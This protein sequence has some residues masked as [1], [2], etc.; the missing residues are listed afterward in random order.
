MQTL[1]LLMNQGGTLGWA[2]AVIGAFGVLLALF[3]LFGAALRSP[4]KVV[5]VLAMACLVLSL[6]TSLTGLI[7]TWVGRSGAEKAAIGK[8]A[9][10][11]ERARLKGF[12]AARA[13]VTLAVPLAAPPLLLALVG[14]FVAARRRLE[15]E[16]DEP[17]PGLGLAVVLLLLDAGAVAASV[18]VQRQP[19]PGEAL[20]DDGWHVREVSDAL[21]AN[22]WGRCLDA[23]WA[24]AEQSPAHTMGAHADNQRK[25]VEHFVA[26]GKVEDLEALAAVKWLE[27]PKLRA[28]LDEKLAAAT[29]ARAAAPTPAPEPA[30]VERNPSVR[31]AASPAADIA[32]VQAKAR[33]CFDKAAKKKKR[34]SVATALA[35]EVSAAGKVVAVRDTGSGRPDAVRKCAV[36]SAKTLKLKAG[37]ARKLDVVLSFP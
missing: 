6:A 13:G 16:H 22:E 7:C 24:L 34:L 15:E 28:A 20:D 18:M 37:D 8:R 35:I 29:S 17:P 33:A 23:K 9:A 11:A 2:V 30:L 10:A 19:P 25:C 36:A 5:R 12:L 3:V 32:L 26:E 1:I 31:P 27:D 14:L 4:S 21:D